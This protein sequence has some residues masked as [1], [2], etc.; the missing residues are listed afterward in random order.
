VDEQVARHNQS[1]GSMDW[2]PS[3]PLNTNEELLLGRTPLAAFKLDNTKLALRFAGSPVGKPW[4][5]D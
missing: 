3:N 1:G 5:T 2:T 4:S